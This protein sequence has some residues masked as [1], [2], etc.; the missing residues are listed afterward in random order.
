[1]IFGRALDTAIP[2]AVIGAAVAVLLAI[3]LIVFFVVGDEIVDGEPVM[4]GDEIDAG[5]SLATAM[6]EAVAGGGEARG[7]SARRHLAAPEIAHGVAEFVVPLG[8][9]RREAADLVAARTA[10]PRLG[11]QF[12]S[13]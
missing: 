3:F 1:L 7:Q 6:V 11:D 13:G 4:G 10:I 8:P 2:R 12:H 5:P 9:A